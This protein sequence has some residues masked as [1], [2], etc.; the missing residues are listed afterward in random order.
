MFS[1][2]SLIL[3]MVLGMGWVCRPGPSSLLGLVRGPF[4]GDGEFRGEVEYRT[5][6]WGQVYLRWVKWVYQWGLGVG[7]QREGVDMY[8]HPGHGT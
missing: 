3:S 4:W 7:M 1:L 8:T 6:D 5:L 2:V